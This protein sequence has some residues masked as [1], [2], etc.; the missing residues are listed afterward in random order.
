ML[1]GPKGDGGFQRVATATGSPLITAPVSLGTLWASLP[2]LVMAGALPGA[3]WRIPLVLTENTFGATQ[4]RA[5]LYLPG[6]M[7]EDHDAWMAAFRAMMADYPS[8]AGY[9][10]PIENGTIQVK[11]R[12]DRQWEVTLRWP[13]QEAS[14]RVMSEEELKT[15]F[16]KVAPEYRYRGDRFLRPSIDGAGGCRHPH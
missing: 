3:G 16:G 1:V 13:T 4:P 11:H 7:P 10:I 8:A 15:F 6:E 14:A 5:T 12:A 2:D 9:G